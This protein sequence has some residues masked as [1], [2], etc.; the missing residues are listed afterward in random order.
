MCFCF[1]QK[2]EYLIDRQVLEISLNWTNYGS[3]T[4]MRLPY[5]VNLDR[6]IETDP[7]SKDSY[8]K[9]LLRSPFEVAIVQQNHK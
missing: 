6:E 7:P 3:D 2:V 1:L 9:N 4:Q 8:K 5:T